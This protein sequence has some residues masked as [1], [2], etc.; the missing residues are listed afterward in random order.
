MKNSNLN[1]ELL[2][3]EIDLSE[4]LSSIFNSKKLII[5]ITLASALLSFIYFSQEDAKYKSTVIIEIGSYNLLNGEKKLVEPIQK[6]IKQLKINLIYKQQLK[7]GKKLNFNSIEDRLLQI[8]F[9]SPSPEINEKIL[10]KAII[11]SQESHMEILF[12]IAN[13][14]SEK[15]KALDTEI[16]FLNKTIEI[17]IKALDSEIKFL[18][19]SIANSSSKTIKAIDNKIPLLKNKIKFLSKLIPEEENNLLLLNSNPAALLQRA[20]TSPTMQQVIYKHNE[21][22]IDLTNEIQNLQQEKD[23]LELQLIATA[24]GEFPSE[25]LL[26]LQIEKDTLE[27]QLIATAEGE[28]PSEELLRLQLEK[29]TLEL[30]LKLFTDQKNNTRLIQELTT[31]QVKSN[32]S[33]KI[34]IGTIFGF[35]LSVLI[36]FIRQFFLKEKN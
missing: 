2:N 36:V 11:F 32:T 28:F 23:T 19:N 27:L 16:E 12:N 8:S 4:L 21:Q 14:T 6:L 22:I 1:N 30:Q 3:D 34:F 35:I 5:L 7:S 9:T 10:K 31:N 20:S 24:E 33:I 15:I 17:K 13:P 25:E 18:K 29:D 26:R